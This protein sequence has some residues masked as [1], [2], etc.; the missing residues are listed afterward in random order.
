[1]KSKVKEGTT[2][3]YLEI[4]EEDKI[5]YKQVK[6]EITREYFQVEAILKLKLNEG[7]IISVLNFKAVSIVRYG[8]GTIEWR[9]WNGRKW[10][11]KP[12]NC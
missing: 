10:I 11:A 4:W 8:T 5:K 12:N 2:D 3:K 7:N 1:M 6:D 9:K